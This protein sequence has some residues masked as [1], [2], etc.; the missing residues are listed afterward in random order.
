MFVD[1]CCAEVGRA[2]SFMDSQWSHFDAFTNSHSRYPMLE[3]F[4]LDEAVEMWSRGSKGVPTSGDLMWGTLRA[5]A[6][7][8][9][10]SQP[11]LRGPHN[12]SF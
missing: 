9:S 1:T 10:R 12:R 11:V 7:R 3:V 8:G 2:A 5:L 6:A 4:M